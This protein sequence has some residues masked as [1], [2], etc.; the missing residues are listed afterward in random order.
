MMIWDTIHAG[1]QGRTGFSIF[2]PTTLAGYN[3]PFVLLLMKSAVHNWQSRVHLDFLFYW[4]TGCGINSTL[5]R[6]GHS[7]SINHGNTICETDLNSLIQL[8]HCFLNEVDRASNM[9]SKAF[10]LRADVSDRDIANSLLTKPD[11]SKRFSSARRPPEYFTTIKRPCFCMETWTQCITLQ[12]WSR[13]G[14]EYIYTRIPKGTVYCTSSN[15]SLAR[16]HIASTSILTTNTS[17][18]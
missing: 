6:G 4:D 17:R 10:M 1:K 18:D 7:T 11:I 3:L 5:I 12:F 8:S 15:S 13:D 16:N 9:A 14:G 2:F